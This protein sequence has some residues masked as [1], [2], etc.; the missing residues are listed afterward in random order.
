MTSILTHTLTHISKNKYH[1]IYLLLLSALGTLHLIKG[2]PLFLIVVAILAIDFIRGK[3]YINLPLL[4]FQWAVVIE[5]VSWIIAI[6]PCQLSIAGLFFTHL[7]AEFFLL[8]NGIFYVQSKKGT[9]VIKTVYKLAFTGTAVFCLLS[10][11]VSY[12]KIPDTHITSVSEALIYGEVTISP[13]GLYDRVLTSD[14]YEMSFATKRYS[15]NQK[16]AVHQSAEGYFGIAPMETDI[17]LLSDIN[18]SALEGNP[19]GFLAGESK[20]GQL[21]YILQDP[22]QG[23]Y[24]VPAYNTSLY[25][26][27]DDNIS[28]DGEKYFVLSSQPYYYS[29]SRQYSGLE[30][31]W[32]FWAEGLK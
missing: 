11:I 8:I 4:M 24:I 9:H 22:A 1:Y 15:T 13:A 20:S 16:F 21:W 7:A 31:Y 5:A 6:L 19:V 14:T 17:L 12:F 3:S 26:V 30:Y 18:N 32:A 2:L 29:L 23:F 27:P 28:A 10:C 25:L